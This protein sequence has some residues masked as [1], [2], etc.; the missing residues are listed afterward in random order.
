MFCIVKAIVTVSLTELIIYT[1]IIVHES[2]VNTATIH[3]EIFPETMKSRRRCR[4]K[5]D[6]TPTTLPH[7][8]SLSLTHT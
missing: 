2:N 6:D 3:H 8:N 5:W 4:E 1:W 7:Y